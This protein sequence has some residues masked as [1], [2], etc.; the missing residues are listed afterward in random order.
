M[1]KIIVNDKFEFDYDKAAIADLDVI[2]D[3][4]NSFHTIH[5]NT[6]VT[7]RV[8][9]S[10]IENKLISVDVD[11]ITY[12]VRIEDA[13]DSLIKDM[14]L[15]ANVVKKLS[16][17]KAP[18]PGLVL[19]IM[20]KAGDHLEEGDSIMILEAMKMENVIKASAEMTIKE[21]LIKKGEAVEKNQILINLED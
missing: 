11:G 7:S 5:G 13:Y 17:V 16:E 21:V 15:S 12:D 8:L 4:K 20:V 9:S 14:G 3:G 10:D 2:A 19:E 18:M 1:Y 6:S